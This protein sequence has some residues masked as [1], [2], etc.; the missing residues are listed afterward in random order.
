MENQGDAPKPDDDDEEDFGRKKK[1]KGKGKA[2]PQ[3]EPEEEDANFGAKRGGKKGK[4]GR[5]ASTAMTADPAAAAA[6]APDDEDDFDFGGKKGKSAGKRQAKTRVRT[7]RPGT[8]TP[9][10]LRARRGSRCRHGSER[11]QALGPQGDEAQRVLRRRGRR[12]VW[13]RSS[14]VRPTSRRVW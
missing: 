11:P 6:A 2:Q 10:R 4:K 9:H 3:E 1:T 8:P 13:L 5:R 14:A 7:S 12:S